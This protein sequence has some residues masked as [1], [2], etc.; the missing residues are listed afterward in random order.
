MSRWNSTDGLNL[1]IYII[2]IRFVQL[3]IIPCFR[4]AHLIFQHSSIIFLGSIQVWLAFASFEKK[5]KREKFPLNRILFIG[6][7]PEIKLFT[8]VRMVVMMKIGW[9]Q[10]M[11]DI[12]VLHSDCGTQEQNSKLAFEKV[13]IR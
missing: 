11:L 12:Y 8:T 4:F 1:F 7:K 5:K 3:Q 13:T 2:R 10:D 9:S 6:I